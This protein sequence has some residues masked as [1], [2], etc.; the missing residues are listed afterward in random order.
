MDIYELIPRGKMWQ[1]KN[2]RTL[3]KAIEDGIRRAYCEA[4]KLLSEC[5]PSSSSL[6]LEDW[7]RICHAKS[8]NGVLST[9]QATGGNTEAFFERIAKQ[10]DKYC[11]VMRNNPQSQF[12]T[13]MS[14]AG[15]SLGAQSIAKFCVVFH[16]SLEG[17][18]E[19][20]EGLL[21]KLKPAHVRFNF[22]YPNLKI[23]PFV[24]GKSC[25]GESLNYYKEFL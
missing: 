21:N 1:G 7:K 15:M 10:F 25:A 12:M 18:I 22:I 19:E 4:N 17:P 23:R 24:A 8:L 5:I 14:S 2:I 20:A 11:Q 6:L 3:F 9:L 13:G 16:F